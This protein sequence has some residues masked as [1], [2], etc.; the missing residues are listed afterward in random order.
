M[1]QRLLTGLALVI[2]ALTLLMGQ[3]CF[4]ISSGTRYLLTVKINPAGAG[5][6]IAYPAADGEGRFSSGTVVTLTAVAASGYEL[7]SW[8]G[9]AAGAGLSVAVTMSADKSVTAT[10]AARQPDSTLALYDQACRHFDATYSY[11]AY[12]NIDWDALR[13]KYRADFVQELSTDAFAGNLATMLR[14]LKDLHVGVRKPNDINVVVYSKNIT[15]N[16]TNTPLKRY[17]IEADDY[18]TLQGP[19]GQNVI[20]HGMVGNQNVSNIAYIRIDTLETEAFS[21][22]SDADIENL[23]RTCSV[24]DG[25]I[26][27]IRPNSGGNDAYAARFASRFIDEAVV[28]GYTQVRNGPAHTDFG[29]LQARVLEPATG[30]HFYGTG[31][32][33]CLIGRKCMSSAEWFTL[34]MRSAGAILIG[35]KTL[36]SSGNPQWFPAD[37]EPTNGVK[38]GI[39]TWI[40]YTND[41]QVIEDNGIS[42]TA[43]FA[44]P[45]GQGFGRSYDSEHDYVLEKALSCFE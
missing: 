3:S 13:D 2:L 21:T 32:V 33:V 38:Y 26:I 35:D 18:G 37:G 23:F 7:T 43:G 39:P 14:E 11:F 36:G 6:V 44:I 12:K 25:M 1:T 5:Q 8:G 10:F 16:Y 30:T 15:G 34:M 24:A 4:P 17:L 41:L 40:A 42:P 31:G 20:Y 45:P 19:S 9:A 22:I 28:Y 27:D 29:P